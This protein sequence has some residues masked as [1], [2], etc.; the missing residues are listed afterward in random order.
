MYYLLHH[1]I[2]ASTMH[3]RGVSQWTHVYEQPKR[4]F[5]LSQ[6]LCSQ[7]GKS[8]CYQYDTY[9]P[10]NNKYLSFLLFI[11][12]FI[13]RFRRTM[14]S[15]QNAYNEDTSAL[16]ERLDCLEKM[17]FVSGQCGLNSFQG[18]EKGQASQLSAS[19][20]VL[21]YR[22][23]KITNVQS[24]PCLLASVQQS[25]TDSS[26]LLLV[27]QRL[28]WFIYFDGHLF[29]NVLWLLP[30]FQ[31]RILGSLKTQCTSGL[32]VRRANQS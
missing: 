27:L 17:L 24:W 6:V 4:S 15:S 14:D 20:L 8:Y 23:R 31:K 11:Q 5:S 18:W 16:V 30:T 9:L 32:R 12:T 28:F 19:S 1:H 10:P 22:K 13:G 26:R 2:V 7:D 25:A 21:N 29:L 3:Y